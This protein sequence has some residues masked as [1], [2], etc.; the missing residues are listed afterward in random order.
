MPKRLSGW[1]GGGGLEGGEV[2]RKRKRML[3]S[4]H[5]NDQAN[6]GDALS[7]STTTNHSQASMTA[8][9]ITETGPTRQKTRTEHSK[10]EKKGEH[11]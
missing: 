5:N 7:Y 3:P 8:K 11:T 6:S 4:C 2:M 9:A 10:P 1:A